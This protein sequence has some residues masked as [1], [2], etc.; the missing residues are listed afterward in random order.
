MIQKTRGPVKN[1]LTTNVSALMAAPDLMQDSLSRW[2]MLV[3][4]TSHPT[5]LAIHGTTL[6]LK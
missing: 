4:T 5:M 3:T 2:R 1:T 6:R